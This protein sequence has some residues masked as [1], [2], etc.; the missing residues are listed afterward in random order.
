MNKKLQ[1]LFEE[2]ALEEV[3]LDMGTSADYKAKYLNQYGVSFK[4]PSIYVQASVWYPGDP[5]YFIQIVNFV[6]PNNDDYEV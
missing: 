2:D 6:V 4:I 3:N 5:S 1:N